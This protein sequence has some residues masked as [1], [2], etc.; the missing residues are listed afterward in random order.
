[1]SEEEAEKWVPRPEKFPEDRM[2]ELE[3]YNWVTA[4]TLRS[5]KQRPKRVKMLMRDFIE[6]TRQRT[7]AGGN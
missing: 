4:Q 2:G 5:R 7:A 3:K 1:M 6:G